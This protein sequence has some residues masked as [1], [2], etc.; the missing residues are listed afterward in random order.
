MSSRVCL[1]SLGYLCVAGITFM[2]VG[3]H[4]ATFLLSNLVT[5]LKVAS[6]EEWRGFAFLGAVKGR[7]CGVFLGVL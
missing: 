1:I 4:M 3:G 6:E 7:L 5:S 2:A